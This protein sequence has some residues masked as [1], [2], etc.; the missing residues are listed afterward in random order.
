MDRYGEPDT[1]LIISL[2]GEPYLG[3]TMDSY[4]CPETALTIVLHGGPY[5]AIITDRYYGARNCH[6]YRLAWKSL[7]IHYNG[8]I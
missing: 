6:Y 3:I 7:I 1:A 4:I 8:P 5:L 2:H